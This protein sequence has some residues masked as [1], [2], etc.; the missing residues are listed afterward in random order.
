M[1]KVNKISEPKLLEPSHKRKYKQQ[2]FGQNNDENAKEFNERNPTKHIA[3]E[4][5]QNI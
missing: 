1:L 2:L 5:Y 3:K 4:K